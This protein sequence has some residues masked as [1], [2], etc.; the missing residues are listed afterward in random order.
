MIGLGGC[1]TGELAR[2]GASLVLMGSVIGGCGTG[3]LAR[4][5][6]LVLMGSLTSVAR[7]IAICCKTLTCFT[8]VRVLWDITDDMEAWDSIST[9]SGD[10]ASSSTT[11]DTFIRLKSGLIAELVDGAIV[12]LAIGAQLV[13]GMGCG[14]LV[15][16]TLANKLEIGF[17]NTLRRINPSLVVPM[18]MVGVA[19]CTPLSRRSF[20]STRRRSLYSD[21]GKKSPYRPLLQ[22]LTLEQLSSVMPAPI[23]AEF[24]TSS[25]DGACPTSGTLSHWVVGVTNACSDLVAITKKK[26]IFFNSY[27]SQNNLLLT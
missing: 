4:F 6:A 22:L 25:P 13:D 3:E 26:Y 9:I 8:P 5:G 1:E 17:S 23:I 15:M 18:F 24:S 19:F 21:F 14:T 12:D 16:F 7:V 10:L 11:A 2:F 20:F 27:I